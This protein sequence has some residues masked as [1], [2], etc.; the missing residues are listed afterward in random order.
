MKQTKNSGL[1]IT[2]FSITILSIVAIL[3]VIAFSE[4]IRKVDWM[5]LESTAFACFGLTILGTILGWCSFQRPLG[6]ISAI[7]GT[8]AICGY[9]FQLLRSGDGH[10]AEATPKIPEKVIHE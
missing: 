1:S 4:G 10:R 6:R 7:L 3:A 8:I 2:A 5:D 9:L